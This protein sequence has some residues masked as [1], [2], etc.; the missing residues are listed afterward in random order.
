MKY[1]GNKNNL[2]QWIIYILSNEKIYL[3]NKIILDGF[4]GTG[5][6]SKVAIKEGAKKVYGCEILK[7]MCFY[8][9]YNVLGINEK[10]FAKIRESFLDKKINNGYFFKNFSTE[11]KRNFFS[12]ENAKKIDSMLESWNNFD[13]VEKGLAIDM[14]DKVSNTAGTYGAFLKIWRSMALKNIEDYNSINISWNNKKSHFKALN[15]SIDKFNK[16]VDI[17]YFDP[18]YNSRQYGSY[19][20]ILERI[21]DR[22]TNINSKSGVLKSDSNSEFSKKATHKDKIFSLIDNV[23]S[24][25]VI[26]SYNNEGIITLSEWKK[27]LSKYKFKIFF[28]EY[29]RYKTNSITSTLTRMNETLKEILF[30]I[31]K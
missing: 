29:K 3:K 28:K 4:L 8:S 30:I 14:V 1:I 26:I 25:V 12:N 9:T 7:S 22:N 21:V 10:S 20:H 15:I 11:S 16:E 24:K 13:E 5:A 19:Y 17:A 23:K 18:P 31:W 6:F 2:I 27:F